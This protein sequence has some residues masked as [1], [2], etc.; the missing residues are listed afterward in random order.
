MLCYGILVVASI[1]CIMSMPALNNFIPIDS[2]EVCKFYT[3]ATLKTIVYGFLGY[4]DLDGMIGSKWRQ[5]VSEGYR[6]AALI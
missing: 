4:D 1:L 2:E 5:V 6:C 3:R